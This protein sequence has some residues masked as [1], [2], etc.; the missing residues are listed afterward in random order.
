MPVDFNHVPLRLKSLRFP[1][2]PTAKTIA[3]DFSDYS[4]KMGHKARGLSLVHSEAFL[5]LSQM[6]FLT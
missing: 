1:F 2:Q 4:F 3:A 6:I 5:N